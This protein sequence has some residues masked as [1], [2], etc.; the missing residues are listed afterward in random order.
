MQEG[1]SVSGSMKWEILQICGRKAKTG[2]WHGDI[3]KLL[4]ATIG[5]HGGVLTVSKHIAVLKHADNSLC[6][7][8]IRKGDYIGLD[9]LTQIQVDNRPAISVQAVMEHAATVMDQ[10]KL[11]VSTDG[12]NWVG[13]PDTCYNTFEELK[14]F[15]FSAR[16]LTQAS[17]LLPCDR[18]SFYA[19]LPILP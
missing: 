17:L 2:L 11:E 8:V 9:L 1:I 10:L 3:T 16:A 13:D 6:P 5:L 4:M 12:Y 7:P 15:M 19:T 14:R 18:P